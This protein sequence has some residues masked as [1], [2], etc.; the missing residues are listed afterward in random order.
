MT[1]L[2]YYRRKLDTPHIEYFLFCCEHT[3]Y[4]LR[5][6]Q[7]Q[8]TYYLQ[9]KIYLSSLEDEVYVPWIKEEKEEA[10]SQ[11]KTILAQKIGLQHFSSPLICD[12]DELTH[13]DYTYLYFLLNYNE[14]SWI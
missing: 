4:L 5:L 7:V 3:N 14:F 1:S 12:E 6:T 9:G 11:L 10:L 13:A 8:S 2:Q